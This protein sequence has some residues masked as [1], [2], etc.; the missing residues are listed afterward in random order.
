MTHKSADQENSAHRLPG[1]GK[2]MK[3]LVTLTIS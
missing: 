3:G 2:A 1:A